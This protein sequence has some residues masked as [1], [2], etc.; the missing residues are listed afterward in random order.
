MENTLAK[1]IE[2]LVHLQK[3]IS[4][5]IENLGNEEYSLLLTLRYLNFKTWEEIAEVMG[6]TYQWVHVMH[7]RALKE[8][9]QRELINTKDGS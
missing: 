2:E 3:S 1:E 9:E 4:S 8:F 5:K 7:K 6:Y